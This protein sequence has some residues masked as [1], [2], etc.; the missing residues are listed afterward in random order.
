MQMQKRMI[1]TLG[2]RGKREY[3]VTTRVELAILAFSH[4]DHVY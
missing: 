3:L 1:N 2:D 4:E